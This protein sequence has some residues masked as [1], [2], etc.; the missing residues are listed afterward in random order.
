MDM[1]PRLSIS[2]LHLIV[3]MVESQS[4]TTSQTAGEAECTNLTIINIWPVRII[5]EYP[6][7]LKKDWTPLTM[8][9]LCDHL[10]EKPGLYLDEMAV[11]MWDEFKTMITTS[12]ITRAL[13]ATGWSKWQHGSALKS[14]TG[15][16]ET[17][18]YILRRV[19]VVSP[20]ICWWKCYCIVVVLM[21]CTA[22]SRGLVLGGVQAGS[23]FHDRSPQYHLTRSKHRIAYL[24]NKTIESLYYCWRIDKYKISSCIA[25]SIRQSDPFLGRWSMN[26]TEFKWCHHPFRFFVFCW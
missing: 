2:K 21:K 14:R 7:R 20:S 23:L 6:N 12:S 11:F 8:I 16:W 22:I 4:F 13:I 1:A 25:A 5:Y 26:R 18:T 17:I 24:K 9:V 15:T 19:S 3:D 10:S